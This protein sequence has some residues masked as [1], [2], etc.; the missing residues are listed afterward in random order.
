MVVLEA[1]AS[2]LPVVT[3][4]LGGMDALVGKAGITVADQRPDTWAFTLKSTTGGE[5]D[6][7]GQQALLRWGEEFSPTV[8]RENLESL[9]RHC[10]S[11]TLSDRSDSERNDGG[12]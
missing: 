11:R 6:E 12:G 3:S 4:N 10:I 1:M 7:M 9:Y 8:A 5:F 2:G